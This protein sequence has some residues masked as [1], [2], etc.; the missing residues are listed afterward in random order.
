MVLSTRGRCNDD[1]HCFTAWT[2]K[3]YSRFYHLC[4]IIMNY[5]PKTNNSKP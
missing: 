4:S 5:Q 1:A 3:T 2:K